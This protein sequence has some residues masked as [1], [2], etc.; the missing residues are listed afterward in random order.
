[1]NLI[2]RGIN[3]FEDKRKNH[4]SELVVVKDREHELEVPATVIEPETY[5]SA[6]R[7]RVKTDKYVFLINKT[8]LESFDVRRG[9][10]IIRNNELYEVVIDKN[11]T[12][13]YNDPNNEVRAVAAQRRA[14]R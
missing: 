6:D 9:L 10:Q 14:Y 12:V 11:A 13:D 1:M 2:S 7:I 5:M 4:V 3:W 8:Y